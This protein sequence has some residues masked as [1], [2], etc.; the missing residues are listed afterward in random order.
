MSRV[1]H[2]LRQLDLNESLLELKGL[3]ESTRH[4][5]AKLIE[6]IENLIENPKVILQ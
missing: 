2:A 3:P 6:R 5:F 1:E 4:I